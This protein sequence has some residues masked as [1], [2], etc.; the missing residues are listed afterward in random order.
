MLKK[1]RPGRTAG[2]GKDPWAVASFYLE[3]CFLLV[4]QKEEEKEKNCQTAGQRKSL[5]R[6]S[7]VLP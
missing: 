2:Q 7:I 6:R 3:V 1:P 4:K 5:K